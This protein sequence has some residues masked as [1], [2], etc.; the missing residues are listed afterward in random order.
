MY[1]IFFFVLQK[2]T[3]TK[4]I[5]KPKKADPIIVCNAFSFIHITVLI[6]MGVGFFCSL[7]AKGC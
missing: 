2:P 3:I 6:D 1:I 5:Q 4:I 7:E